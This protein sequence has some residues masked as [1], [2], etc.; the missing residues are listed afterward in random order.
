MDVTSSIECR[1]IMLALVKDQ[2]DEA[3][4]HLKSV[5][6]QEPPDGVALARR[7]VARWRACY[8]LAREDLALLKL[9]QPSTD[10]LEQDGYIAF[11]EGCERGDNPWPEGTD[12]QN[13]WWNGWD[14]ANTSFELKAGS[15]ANG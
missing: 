12:G 3:E 6:A 4:N 10:E 15:L 1:K 5:E 14:K 2:L 11:V 9:R 8:D 7:G 13:A